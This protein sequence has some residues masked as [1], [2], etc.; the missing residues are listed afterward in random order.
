MTG[1]TKCLYTSLCNPTPPRRVPTYKET[2]TDPKSTMCAFAYS[3]TAPCAASHGSAQHSTEF[4]TQGNQQ[5][6]RLFVASTQSAWHTA[7]RYTVSTI[8]TVDWQSALYT[9]S[10]IQQ[11]YT[12]KGKLYSVATG[13]LKG[14]VHSL[15]QFKMRTPQAHCSYG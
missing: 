9:V 11:P 2:V 8:H 6:H 4:S 10:T 14:L 15:L 12:R 13:A 5:L 1:V 7:A 3:D